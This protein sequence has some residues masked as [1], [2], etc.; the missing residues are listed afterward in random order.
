MNN[1]ANVEF[2]DML[3]LAKESLKSNTDKSEYTQCIVM[4]TAQG[5]NKLYAFSCNT[6]GELLEQSCSAI[7]KDNILIVKKLLC[8]WS[9]EILDV[10]SGRFM[11]TLCEIDPNNKNAEVLLKSSVKKISEIIN[12]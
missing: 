11:S 5:E 6:V 8:M 12:V 9:G 1:I 2:D 4:R 7:L 10:P 3:S